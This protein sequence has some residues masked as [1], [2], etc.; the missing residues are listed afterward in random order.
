MKESPYVA[1][2]EINLARKFDTDSW[3]QSEN[4]KCGGAAPP[5]DLSLN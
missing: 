3:L 2:N 4:A 1:V 5:S